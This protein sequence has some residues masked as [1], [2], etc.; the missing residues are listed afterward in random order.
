MF[1]SNST[2]NKIVKEDP[3]NIYESERFF[4]LRHN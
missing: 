2:T 4:N 1:G 3:K